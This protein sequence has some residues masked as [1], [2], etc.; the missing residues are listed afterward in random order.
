MDFDGVRNVLCVRLDNLGDVLMT[1][2]A[3][4]ALKTLPG[5]PRLTLLGSGAGAAIAPLVPEIDEVIRWEAPWM[6]ASAPVAPAAAQE[7]IAGLARRGFDAAVIFTVYSQSPLPAALCCLLAG[8]PRRLA[9]CREN[10]Y[11]LL[12]HWIPEC[13]PE[14]R[15]RH[16]V[17]RQLDL[18]AAVGACADDERLSLRLDPA[19][20]ARAE[21]WI[22]ELALPE[23]GWAAIHP[24]ASAPSRRYPPERF[25][26]V[27]DGLA[28]AGIPVVFLGGADERALV[29][30]VRAAM[31]SRAPSLVGRTDLAT[32]AAL[33]ARAPVLV[34]N[35]S[36]PA[37]LA[38]AVGT[39][40][41]SLYA[42]TNPQ[43]TP[44][45]V[46]HRLLNRL[47]PCAFCYKSVCPEGHHAC[48]RAVS[49][50]QVIAAALE[51]LAAR[52]SAHG[53]ALAAPRGV[54]CAPAGEV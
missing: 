42:L 41:V 46:P 36:G 9:H 19:A 1:T 4:R 32:L 7:G 17:R 11:Q 30:Q 20:R 38:A 6:K 5:A 29:E 16:E 53:R 44:W 34:A 13:E 35:N 45:G 24:G 37:H 8:I 43:H 15:I 54:A 25:A 26:A 39:P 12:T 22:A 49:P 48:L 40:I 2:P 21:R 50:E 3:L 52:R 10:P 27:A 31:A 14:R 51:L 23:G 33:L 28:G 47:V 18:V